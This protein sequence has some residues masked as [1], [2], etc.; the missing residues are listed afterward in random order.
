MLE[1]PAPPE[2]VRKTT[3]LGP[4]RQVG[5][6]HRFRCRS[7]PWCNG[8]GQRGHNHHPA[9]DDHTAD[10]SATIREHGTRS[11]SGSRLKFGHRRG[12]G[13]GGFGLLAGGVGRRD[14]RL[15][16]R[17]YF[18]S[19]GATPLNRPVVGMAATWT[20]KGYWL[21]A[22]DGGVFAFGDAAYCGSTGALHLNRP[23][24]GMGSVD[25]CMAA[26]PW[27]IVPTDQSISYPGSLF[28]VSCTSASACTAVGAFGYNGF[29]LAERWDGHGWTVQPI[30]DFPNAIAQSALTAVS[31]SSATA[32][33]AIGEVNNNLSC[34]RPWLYSESWDGVTWTRHDIGS[35]LQGGV[36][37]SCT[38]STFCMAVWGTGTVSVVER[39]R[40]LDISIGAEPGWGN[41]RRPKR[42][43][44][45]IADGLC[46][47][48]VLRE[49][50]HRKTLAATWDGMGWTL[51]PTPN[52]GNA[53]GTFGPSLNAV[54]CTSATTCTA[55]GSFY[56]GSNFFTLAERWD[57]T[58]WTLQPTPNPTGSAGTI[59]ALLQAVSCIS[60]TACTAVGSY[61]DPNFLTLAEVWDG[62]NWSI[63]PTPNPV[64]HP[65]NGG[66]NMLRGISCVR[67]TR[68]TAVGSDSG[69]PGLFVVQR[70]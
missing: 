60:P 54:S 26:G 5:R 41:R 32:C 23:I 25:A 42:H 69:S 70:P 49:L 20:A 12:F 66:Q 29:P 46:R 27:S 48:G 33:M 4:R 44:V 8:P 67:V 35:G 18:G 14:L 2:G 11:L 51:Q 62:T 61:S 68:C 53:A 56:D 1:S 10:H 65:E 34:C 21:V 43:L 45:H 50:G 28:A 47:R 6:R 30:P 57:G 59:G 31:C 52:P 36:D 55:V 37:V 13:F 7:W 38:S 15:R 24:V 40:E 39:R 3:P 16:R 58:A 19:S 9:S 22:S 63:L 64:A 17:C